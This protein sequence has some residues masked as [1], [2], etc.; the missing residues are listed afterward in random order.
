MIH[1]QP[2]KTDEKMCG[3]VE[4][5]SPSGDS[6]AAANNACSADRRLL[7]I[8]AVLAHELRNPLSVIQ[9]S[10]DLMNP[11]T[12]A[13]VRLQSTLRKQVERMTHLVNDMLD[14]SRSTNGK[15]Q[16][17]RKPSDL[18][19]IVESAVQNMSSVFATH[20][21][22]LEILIDDQPCWINADAH[23]VSQVLINL[24]S[25]ASKYSDEGSQVRLHVSRENAL[26]EI[27]VV[28]NGIGIEP[29]LLP[30]VFDF[31]AQSKSS[32]SL[33]HRDGGLGI[34]LGLVK[35]IVE[36]HDGSVQAR[37]GGRGCGSEFVVRLPACEPM[38]RSADE[39][40]ESDPETQNTSRVLVVDDRRDNEFVVKSL[41]RRLG[42]YDVHSA[43]NGAA[44]LAAIKSFTPDIVILDLGLPD[45]T[46]LELAREI[47]KIEACRET[48]LVALT[49]YDDKETRQ[50][51]ASSGI[52]VYRVKPVSMEMLAEVFRH[53]KLMNREVLSG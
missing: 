28:D 27:R 45:M 31:F 18:K 37:S 25:N 2:D 3:S 7:R 1:D 51:A 16:L 12:E 21:Q 41:I 39:S 30:D 11:A 13:D 48:F 8:C 20:R 26:I 50:A 46:G 24:F 35:S 15:T 42:E 14:M 10:A 38:D 44:A 49:G 22:S 29:D 9:A 32:V 23:R 6:R 19:K 52:D 36:M 34:G 5:H 53:P 33:E 17:R 43:H 40:H 4:D 47:R